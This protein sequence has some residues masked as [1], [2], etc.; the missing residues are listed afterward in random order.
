MPEE[1]SA[2]I[3]TFVMPEGYRNHLSNS[4]F[5]KF[6]IRLCTVVVFTKLPLPALNLLTSVTSYDLKNAV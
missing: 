5:S 1:L 3:G 2:G 6:V 4:G